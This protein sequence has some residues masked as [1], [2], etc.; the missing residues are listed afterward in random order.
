VLANQELTG[1]IGGR[2]S[3]VNSLKYGDAACDEGIQYGVGAE[4]GFDGLVTVGS[5]EGR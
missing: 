1:G 4:L 2:F 3:I 5:H